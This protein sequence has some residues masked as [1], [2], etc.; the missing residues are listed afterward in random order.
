[1]KAKNYTINLLEANEG[2]WLIQKEVD[3]IINTVFCKRVLYE[4]DSAGDWIEITNEEKELL[5][6]QIKQLTQDN[7]GTENI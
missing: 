1:M 2:M 4:D 5:Q 6:A 3:S 7:E